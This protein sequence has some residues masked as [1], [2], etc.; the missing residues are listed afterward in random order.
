MQKRWL[1]K[2]IPDTQQ[3]KL[4]CQAINISKPIATILLQRGVFDYNS[5]KDF[6]R[7][8]VDHLHDPFQ[9]KDMDIA[10]DLVAE[11]IK[12]GGKILVYGDYDVDGTT[13]VALVYQYLS[14]LTSNIEYY[15]PD[16]YTEGYGVSEKGMSY[17]ITNDFNLIITLDCGI[18]A[19]NTLLKA[20]EAGIDIIVCDHHLPGDNLPPANAV[21]DPKRSDCSYPYKELSGCGIGFKLLQGHFQKYNPPVNPFDYI[22]LVA[23]S[24]AADIVPITGENRVLTYFGLKKLNENPSP[25]LKALMD[26]SASRPPMDVSSVVFNIAPRINAAGRI[27]HADVAVDLLISKTEE[28]A[29]EHASKINVKNDDRRKVDALITEEALA[30]I[31]GNN[32]L[33]LAKSTVL[34]KNDW[35]KGVIGIVASRC[36]EK[37]YRPTIILTESNNKATGS[38]RS[39]SGFDVYKAIEACS[40]LLEQYGGHTHAAGLTMDI[41]KVALFQKRFEE[42]VAQNISD[43][44]LVPLLEID[45][46]LNFEQV[47]PNFFNVLMQMAPFG[48]Y[49]LSPLFVTS[50]VVATGIKTINDK[51]LKFTVNQQG[52]TKKFEV[53]AYNMINFNEILRNGTPFDLAYS[54][55]LNNYMGYKSIQLVAK[56]IKSNN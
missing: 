15:V 31:E 5:A 16:R 52:R 42:V 1:Y 25:G 7:P 38:A 37:F 55:E 54:L 6:F 20:K 21:L 2:D 47:T 51:H 17:A 32:Q 29:A 13:S 50:D 19:T 24:I 35:H 8:S 56:D 28:E 26:I 14:K 45:I 30:M 39:I 49:N 53:I 12:K 18:K 36:I 11:N 40:D 3:I 46:R 34:F 33:Q 44:M 10:V 41:S 23:V 43:D 48:P 9:M 22:E 27:T 4:L